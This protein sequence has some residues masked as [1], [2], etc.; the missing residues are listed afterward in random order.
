MPEIGA[1]LRETRMR[2]GLEISDI[3]ATTKIRAKYLRAI[4]NEEWDLLPGTTFVKSFLRTYAEA[5]D[6]DSRLLLEEYKSR[7][8]RFDEYEIRP[9]PSGSSHSSTGRERRP[10]RRGHPGRWILLA[11]AAMVVVIVLVLLGSGSDDKVS[12]SS[13]TSTSAK[14]KEAPP[15]TTKE[16]D[17]A[18]KTTAEKPRE[19][20][21]VRAVKLQ[22]VPTG[23]VYAC[24]FAGK[25][26]LIT[27]QTF[28]TGNATSTFRSKHF[29]VVLGNGNARLKVDGKS[30]PVADS[31]KPVGYSITSSGRT[32]LSAADVPTC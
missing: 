16:K 14:L 7:Y 4:E 8:E 23:Q 22:I 30:T 21:T 2:L 29:I 15:K 13:T 32:R 3:E 18:P 26:R 9:T 28:E 31:G 10:P 12:G 11:C 20:P 5:L 24:L 1:T 17:P 27:G 19:K 25:R 6:L